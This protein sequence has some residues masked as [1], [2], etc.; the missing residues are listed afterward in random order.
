VAAKIFRSAAEF[1]KWLERNHDQAAELWLGIYN[2]RTDKKSITYREALDEALCFGW[3]DG[4]RKS[5]NP[6]TYQQ[7]FSPRRPQSYWSAV[8]IR[9]WH[10]L[11]KLGREA[12]AGVEAFERRRPDSARYS[13]ESRPKKLPAACERQFRAH[14]AA[15]EFFRAQAPWY[16][17]TS[18]FW[19]LSAKR[20]PTRQRRLDMLIADSEQGRRLDMLTSKAKKAKPARGS[21]P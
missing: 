16:Q 11:V 8:N 21:R 7:R 19:V 9:R 15:W 1:R 6:T 18:S 10:E 2:Q 20:E 13:F 12:P 4:V 14:R 17:R 3:I 5:I